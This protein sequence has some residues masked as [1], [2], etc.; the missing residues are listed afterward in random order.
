MKLVLANECDFGKGPEF[1]SYRDIPI[2]EGADEI[3]VAIVES[4][5]G[6]EIHHAFY[7]DGERIEASSVG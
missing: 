5:D 7:A 3:R 1:S 6:P 4:Y 2:P